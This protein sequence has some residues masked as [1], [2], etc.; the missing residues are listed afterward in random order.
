[1][2]SL[3]QDGGTPPLMW[4][5][6]PPSSLP[7]NV[8]LNSS[9]GLLYGTT[10]TE[11]SF[12]FTVKVTD[13]S[14]KP[15]SGTQG[16]TLQIQQATTT[17]SVGSSSSTSIYGVPVTY[18]A[19]VAPTG[20][21]PMSG[22][23]TFYDAGA[24]IS[25]AIP[26]ISGATFST[27][28]YSPN[29]MQLTAGTHSITAV[30]S[31]DPNFYA[32]GSGGSTASPLTQTVKPAPLTATVSG[33]E[34]SAPPTFTVTGIS[35][36]T[37]AGSDAESSPVNGTLS[38][39]VVV[40]SGGAPSSTYP[41]SCTGLSAA[42]YDIT[43]NY[44][45]L[46]G[47]VAASPATLTVNV[48]GT[49]VPGTPNTFAIASYTVS[50]LLSLDTSAVVTG[51]L[52][53]AVLAPDYS[54]NNYPISCSGLSVTG[55][56]N[57]YNIVYNYSYGTP[58]S[59]PPTPSPLTVAVNGS[60]KLGGTPTFTIKSITYS[61]FMNG[62]TP[63]VVSGTLSCTVSVPATALSKYP[64]TCLGL[65]ANNYNISYDYTNAVDT[66]AAR[67]SPLIVTVTGTPP[68]VAYAVSG[69]VNGDAP[70]VVTGTLT[71]TSGTADGAGNV[72]ISCTGLS[73]T[74]YTITYSYGYPPSTPDSTLTVNVIGT[75]PHGST[76]QVP[77]PPLTIT[78]VT[79]SGFV[80]DDT[81]SAVTGTLSCT[82]QPGPNAIPPSFVIS[83]CSGITVP[84]YYA[85]I[86]Y[87]FGKVTV[88]P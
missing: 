16:L 40:P 74:N 12:G 51:T 47:I 31:G 22:T 26:V 71:C 57:T 43:Y 56:T 68:S 70:T 20:G 54:S 24:P 4:S 73:A 55:A 84:G 3:T 69:L 15:N 67:P 21:C 25:G 19:T 45:S 64:I 66:T 17:T 80:N 8:M 61:G 76:D 59:P 28:S 41:I 32:T 9:T 23:V 72:P 52:T 50:G 14:S 6:P 7:P 78:S 10:C 35:Y 13:S 53:C 87:W 29:L 48:N 83:G 2:F 18:T 82:T 5:V 85:P 1:M 79:Y 11:G 44:G 30:Y 60:V 46:S 42:N 86:K 49:L 75:V 63:S 62:D 36:A 88:A 37:F 58:N 81:L 65:T 27:A 77:T 34:S 33:T 39:A 38:C